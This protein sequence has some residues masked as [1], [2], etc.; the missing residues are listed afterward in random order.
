M[1]MQPTASLSPDDFEQVVSGIVAGIRLSGSA[2]HG[3]AL[4]SGRSNRIEGASGYAHQIDVSLSAPSRVF[5]LECKRYNCRVGVEAVLVLAARASDIL[6]KHQREERQCVVVPILVTT[7]GATRHALKLATHFGVR[8]EVV[9]SAAHYGLKLGH[10][11]AVGL[12]SALH[13]TDRVEA[14]VAP[15]KP[16]L[17]DPEIERAPESS[18][19]RVALAGSA[20]SP[21]AGSS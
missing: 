15:G 6:E 16:K 13:M 1:S 19:R 18:S 4:G 20:E 14:E 3:Y 8:V 21:N 9:V 11:A 7:K 17:S 10:I 2:S 5:L 12:L